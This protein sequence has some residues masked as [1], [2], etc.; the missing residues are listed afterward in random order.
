VR[1]PDSLRKLNQSR[2][3]EASEFFNT[4]DGKLAFAP[5]FCTL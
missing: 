3:I 2:V 4:I 1:D 5:D